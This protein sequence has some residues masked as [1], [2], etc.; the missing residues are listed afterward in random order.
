[1]HRSKGSRKEKTIPGNTFSLALFSALVTVVVVSFSC[2]MLSNEGLLLPLQR[3]LAQK[4]TLDIQLLKVC[5][6][7]FLKRSMLVTT[8]AV[9]ESCVS[10]WVGSMGQCSE[11]VAC[12]VL[13]EKCRPWECPETKALWEVTR[14]TRS[15]AAFHIQNLTEAFS[16]IGLNLRTQS[17]GSLVLFLFLR[18][19]RQK[20][21][22]L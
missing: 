3:V 8:T 14:T 11:L 7:R 22:P 21:L 15:P 19:K 5:R 18:Y 10:C 9:H 4:H 20:K 17:R 6:K 1:M 2:W 16:P 12:F 13:Y